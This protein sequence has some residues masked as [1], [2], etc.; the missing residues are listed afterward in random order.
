M[1]PSVNAS[2]VILAQAPLVD[3]PGFWRGYRGLPEARPGYRRHSDGWWYP[4]AA[5]AAGAVLGG[6]IAAQESPPPR[7]EYAAPPPPPPPVDS[8][9][10]D[11]RHYDWCA[12][13]YRSYRAYDNSFQPHNGPR[14]QCY[15]PYG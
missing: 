14:R 7:P 10:Y 1:L 5:F 9:R 8:A 2:N 11:P 3:G 15:S 12:D 13:K 4:L 6:A